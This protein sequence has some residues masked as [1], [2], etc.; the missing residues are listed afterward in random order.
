MEQVLQILIPLAL[1]ALVATLG[2][3]FYALYRGGDFGR[4]WSNKLMRVR[5][6]LQALAVVLLVLFVVF[7][8][9]HH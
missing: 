5:I 3:G 4:A 6:G 8:H 7:R 9:G 2:M 1:L